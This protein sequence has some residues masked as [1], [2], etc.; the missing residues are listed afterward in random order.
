M[1]HAQEAEDVGIGGPQ[2]L[3]ALM[4]RARA[5][6]RGWQQLTPAAPAFEL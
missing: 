6:P 3:E 2:P 1:E 5:G 4:V